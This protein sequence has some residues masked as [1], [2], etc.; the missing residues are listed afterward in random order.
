MKGIRFLAAL[1]VVFS[2]FVAEAW[3]QSP[4]K[5]SKPEARPDY[6]PPDATA[7]KWTGDLDGMIKRRMIRVLV[8]YSK[9]NYFV[10]RGTQR[11]LTY[12]AF[13]LFEED[14][15]K[16][17]KSKTRAHVLFVPVSRDELIPA[18]LQGRG[19]IAA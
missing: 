7:V 5:Q 10:D 1:A 15:N 14:L 2:F 3:G 17:L 12:D 6:A 9:T 8:T 19:D 4:S 16:Q 18:L 11:G 13:R